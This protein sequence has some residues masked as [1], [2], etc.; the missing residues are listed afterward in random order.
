[1]EFLIY[2]VRNATAG[3]FI[4]IF[5]GARAQKETIWRLFNGIYMMD[6]INLFDGSM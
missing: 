2:Y 5:K 6:L 1:M 3:I 4:H